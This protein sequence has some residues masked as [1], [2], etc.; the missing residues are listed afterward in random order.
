MHPAGNER[1]QAASPM[2]SGEAALLSASTLNCVACCVLL[3]SCGAQQAGSTCE[4]VCCSIPASTAQHRQGPAG[5]L[6]GRAGAESSTHHGENQHAAGQDGAQPAVPPAPRAPP[7]Q[8]VQP[9][10]RPPP[11]PAA[12]HA[13]RKGTSCVSLCMSSLRARHQQ[14]CLPW[15]LS[16]IHWMQAGSLAAARSRQLRCGPKLVTAALCASYIRHH[17]VT[18][19]DYHAA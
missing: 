7:P 16:G 6:E 9:G 11:Q 2:A 3:P 18:M 13:L 8:A 1:S 14:R 19:L 15:T 5:D 4:C 10:A 17:E 12:V